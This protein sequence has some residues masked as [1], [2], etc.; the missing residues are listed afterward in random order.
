MNSLLYSFSV[1]VLFFQYIRFRRLVQLSAG[2]T[3]A[4]SPASGGNDIV[5]FATAVRELLF[6]KKLQDILLDLFVQMGILN[7]LFLGKTIKKRLL[8]I[9]LSI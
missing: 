5:S 8:V 9:T 1:F 7:Q 6:L 2:D 4:E 3:P